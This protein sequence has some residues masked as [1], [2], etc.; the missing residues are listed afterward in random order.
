MHT[1]LRN[2]HASQASGAAQKQKECVCGRAG[3]QCASPALT[4]CRL[5]AGRHSKAA[6]IAVPAPLKPLLQL[7]SRMGPVSKPSRLRNLGVGQAAAD[8]VLVGV[9][10]SHHLAAGGDKTGEMDMQHE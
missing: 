9:A 5:Q 7:T 3:R 8:Q 1:S 10:G 2:L 6:G 4:G